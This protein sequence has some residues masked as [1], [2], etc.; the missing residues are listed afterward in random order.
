MHD[1]D[2]FDILWL[3]EIGFQPLHHLPRKLEEKLAL[4]LVVHLRQIHEMTDEI[5]FEALFLDPFDGAREESAG[6]VSQALHH[7]LVGQR[8]LGDCFEI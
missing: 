5:V 6:L 1:E 2:I 7:D 4:G 8:L 3:G